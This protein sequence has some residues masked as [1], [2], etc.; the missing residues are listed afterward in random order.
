MG[1]FYP[2]FM[3]RDYSSGVLSSYQLIYFLQL[4][5]INIHFFYMPFNLVNLSVKKRS[6]SYFYNFSLRRLL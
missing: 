2:A 1:A 6:C 4:Y 3:A 5:K